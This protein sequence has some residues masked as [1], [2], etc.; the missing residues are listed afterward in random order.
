MAE[1][2][3]THRS[4]ELLSNNL[5][6]AEVDGLLTVAARILVAIAEGLG[7][8]TSYTQAYA[9]SLT[10]ELASTSNERFELLIAGT[11]GMERVGVLEGEKCFL[12]VEE[13]EEI[14]VILLLVGFVHKETL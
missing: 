2:G 1:L 14:R 6:P 3:Q 5:E 12:R 4:A 13:D 10:K 11:A 7:N 8:K 9:L